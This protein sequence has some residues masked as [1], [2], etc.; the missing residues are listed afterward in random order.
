MKK[1]YFYLILLT[2]SIITFSA[3]KKLSSY[4]YDAGKTNS[5]SIMADDVSNYSLFKYIIDRAALTAEVQ[6]GDYTIFAP[7]NA[8][9]AA[10]GYSTKNLENIAIDTIA[11]FVKNHLVKE[12]IDLS[13]ITGTRQVTAVAGNSITLEK[14]GDRLYIDGGNITNVSKHV[15][16]GSLIT[17]NK[18]LVKGNSIYERLKKYY[19]Y[20]TNNA[21]TMLI[22]AIDKASSGSVNYKNLLSDSTANYTF[23]APTNYAFIKAGYATV[24]SVTA[25]NA[26]TLGNLLSNHIVLGKRFTTQ[27]D[28]TQTIN[29]LS[30]N[31]IFSDRVYGGNRYTHFYQNGLASSGGEANIEAGA[32]IIN[33]VPALMPV[34][35]NATTLAKIQADPNL[36]FFYKALQVGTSAGKYD[37]INMLSGSSDTYTVFAIKNSGFQNNGYPTIQSITD[38]N[39]AAISDMLLFH[40]VNKRISG[41]NYND[42]AGMP[43]M[44][45][46]QNISGPPTRVAITI[47]NTPKYNVK[48]PTNPTSYLVISS[49]VTNN[50][51]L[52]V[53]DGILTP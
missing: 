29:A 32:G 5:Y 21:F 30:G 39:P 12:K 15:T 31:A 38:A 24:A 3:C 11:L 41:F 42:N 8:A 22:A 40:F 16:N 34:S 51:L 50:G 4:D 43:S 9:F 25:A 1:K 2:G 19:A 26:N 33:I 46:Q 48:G 23:F 7:T 27:L 17:I 49:Q 13:T 45:Y 18:L 44:Y 36:S 52:N 10:A 47:S 53:I 28:T 20:S 37:F 35:V 6:N 14:I